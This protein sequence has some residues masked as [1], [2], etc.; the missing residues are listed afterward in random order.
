MLL[1]PSNVQVHSDWCILVTEGANKCL[2]RTKCDSS[3][4]LRRLE[5]REAERED[6]R[7]GIK[8]KN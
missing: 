7:K 8:D 2:G 4:Q 5:L 3:F 6:S 1:K